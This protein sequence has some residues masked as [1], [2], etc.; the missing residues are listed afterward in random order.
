MFLNNHAVSEDAFVEL[1][2]SWHQEGYCFLIQVCEK[3]KDTHVYKVHPWAS[4][5]ENKFNFESHIKELYGPLYVEENLRRLLTVYRKKL[6]D[7]VTTPSILVI[8]TPEDIDRDTRDGLIRDTVFTDI[9]THTLPPLTTTLLE[10]LIFF[11][12]KR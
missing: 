4:A 5:N 7:A 3:R 1:A 11:N 6:T 9:Q 10:K 8:K 2:K 12:S